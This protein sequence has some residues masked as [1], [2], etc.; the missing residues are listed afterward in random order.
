MCTLHQTLPLNVKGVASQTRSKLGYVYFIGFVPYCV[1]WELQYTGTHQPH[2]TY[3]YSI[4]VAD[5][6]LQMVRVWPLEQVTVPTLKF[7]LPTQS[8]IPSVLLYYLWVWPLYIGHTPPLYTDMVW[9]I[10]LRLILMWIKHVITIYI[11]SYILVIVP[12][13]FHRIV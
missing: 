5:A 6:R 4:H 1:I 7:I 10:F 11:P 8:P 2:P 12:F 9:E 13:R 3:V